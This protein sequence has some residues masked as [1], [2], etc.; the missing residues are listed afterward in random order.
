MNRKEN[1]E[2]EEM[3]S[4]VQEAFGNHNGCPLCRL[5]ASTEK[6][7]MNTVLSGQSDAEH[8]HM[9]MFGFCRKHW[10]TME[11]HDASGLAK[12]LDA[13]IRY[14]NTDV[15]MNTPQSYPF[16]HLH[17]I[18]V[19]DHT[20][21]SCYICDH[22]DKALDTYLG[23]ILDLWE[24]NEEFCSLFRARR[25]FCLPH[26]RDLLERAGGKF[27]KHDMNDF[28]T[29]VSEIEKKCFDSLVADTRST[30]EGLDGQEPDADQDE[31]EETI[32]RVI[33]FLMG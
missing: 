32:H 2:M 33:S 5:L 16:Q 19:I 14:I 3:R 17:T 24:N 27:K 1:S 29:T 9:D 30:C 6:N 21:S 15:F 8:Q 22:V 12:L 31:A 13:R 20:V 10:H 26:Y 4:T 18:H 25:Y 7:V 28:F 11:A 23:V